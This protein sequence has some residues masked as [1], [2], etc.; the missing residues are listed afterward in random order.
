MD[1]LT[2]RRPEARRI[3]HIFCFLVQERPGDPGELG[4][5]KKNEQKK[6]GQ[7]F[8]NFMLEINRLYSFIGTYERSG[9]KG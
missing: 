6:V 2:R 3:F 9:L 7:E 8:S 5:Q 1:A 4:N